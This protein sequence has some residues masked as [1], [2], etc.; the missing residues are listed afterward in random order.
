MQSSSSEKSN[1]NLISNSSN[2]PINKSNSNLYYYNDYI[3]NNTDEYDLKSNIFNPSKL[4]PPNIWKNRLENRIKIYSS[5][6][7]NVKIYNNIKNLK[8]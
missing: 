6:F 4:S 3:C 1:Y 8:L 7:D 2:I 5:D